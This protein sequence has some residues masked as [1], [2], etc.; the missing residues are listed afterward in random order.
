LAALEKFQDEF[1]CLSLTTTVAGS[2]AEAHASRAIL[3]GQDFV[4]T[5]NYYMADLDMTA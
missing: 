3:F 5:L 2:G 4:A 1:L